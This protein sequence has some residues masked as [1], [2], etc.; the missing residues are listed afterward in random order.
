[1]TFIDSHAHLDDKQFDKDRDNVI[2]NLKSNEIS[3]V[4]NIGS[5]IE[6]SRFS[7]KL[8]RDNDNI[9][10]AAGV[11]PHDSSSCTEEI[12]TEI[13]KLLSDPKCVAL[14]EI[15]LDYF[16][17]YSPADIQREIFDRQLS[18]AQK[19]EIPVCIHMREAT[20][21]TVDFLKKYSP[22]NK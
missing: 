4:I 15:G 16:K 5:D 1:M 7:Q 8:A 18:I 13:E 11:H 20:K 12:L 3:L 21:D 17:N 9:Y 2:N 22:F 19:N 14:G 6:S 10:F